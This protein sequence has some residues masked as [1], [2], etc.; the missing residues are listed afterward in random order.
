MGRDPETWGAPDS[1]KNHFRGRS[2]PAGLDVPVDW[3]PLYTAVTGA[4]RKTSSG[5][6][7]TSPVF[8]GRGLYTLPRAFTASLPHLAG[9]HRPQ[10]LRGPAA[11]HRNCDQSPGGPR[12]T[13]LP[14]VQ[15]LLRAFCVPQ[16]SPHPD[17]PRRR[18]PLYGNSPRPEVKGDGGQL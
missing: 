8:S 16:L 7:P 6:G 14:P 15:G 12:S 9:A 3:R 18:R 2:R 17:I 5:L 4:P 10:E 1:A 13:S 11:Q